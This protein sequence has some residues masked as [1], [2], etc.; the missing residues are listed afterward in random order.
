M[1]SRRDFFGR[2]ARLAEDR[3]RWREKRL[4]ELREM[5]LE[6]APLNWTEDQREETLRALDQKLSCL[7][8]DA[9]R[10]E[11]IRKYVE[12]LVRTKEMFYAAQRAE[13]EYLRRQG[14]DSDPY[15]SE[16]N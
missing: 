4:A 11:S 1:Y 12:G 13:Q 9:L 14:Q 6:V 3:R 2:V 8:D 5:A 10:Q 16:E 15:P 7:N